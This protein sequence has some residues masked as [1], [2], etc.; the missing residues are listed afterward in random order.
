MLFERKC[1]MIEPPC[2]I[3]IVLPHVKDLIVEK[4]MDDLGDSC[5]KVR[6]EVIPNEDRKFRLKSFDKNRLTNSGL[7]CLFCNASW[8]H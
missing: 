6:Y 4:K 2:G 5:K 7:E 1:F 8:P 3:L